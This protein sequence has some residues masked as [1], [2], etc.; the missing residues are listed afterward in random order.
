MRFQ[1]GQR[2]FTLIELLVVVAV[3]GLLAAIAIPS[4]YG[5]RD[6]AA[7]AQSQA[8]LDSV[9]TGLGM[10][11]TDQQDGEYPLTAEIADYAALT[12]VLSAYVD[13]PGAGSEPFTFTSYASADGSTYSLVV[14]ANDSDSTAITLT[15]AG[16]N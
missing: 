10:Y 4:Y 14:A 9:K 16:V 2:G 15:P 3:V 7:I 12:T 1:R 5:A 8:V 6:R 11:A 13:L